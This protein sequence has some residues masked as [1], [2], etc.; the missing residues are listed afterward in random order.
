[1]GIACLLQR[2]NFASYIFPLRKASKE[3]Q[4]HLFCS[5]EARVELLSQSDWSER[6]RYW[7]NADEEKGGE[8]AILE[9][10]SKSIGKSTSY[11]SYV[12]CGRSVG[13]SLESLRWLSFAF[14]LSSK[15]NRRLS[16]RKTRDGIKPNNMLAFDLFL[17]F[18]LFFG[19]VGELCVKKAFQRKKYRHWTAY[20][21]KGLKKRRLSFPF[22]DRR[23]KRKFSFAGG[24]LF[25]RTL[26]R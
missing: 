15:S 23:K 14:S 22:P 24:F 6:E 26:K 16:R 3:D 12:R 25:S 18:G 21:A 1:M 20:A 10:S 19:F 11:S 7:K 2:T 4:S 17:A 9:S 13:R 8:I 5:S